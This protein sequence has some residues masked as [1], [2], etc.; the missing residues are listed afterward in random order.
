M[1]FVSVEVTKTDRSG[2]LHQ[3]H[4]VENLSPHEKALGPGGFMIVLSNEVFL[5]FKLFPVWG[6]VSEVTVQG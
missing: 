1:P 2:I 4:E 6:K 3:D 5:L